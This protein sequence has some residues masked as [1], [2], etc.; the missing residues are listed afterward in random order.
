MTML[1]RRVFLS[2]ASSLVLLTACGQNA[3]ETAGAG[4]EVVLR[5]GNMAE[6]TSLNPHAMQGTWDHQI[7]GDMF[8]GL[9]TEDPEGRPVPAAAER[10]ETS[11]DGLTWTF[12]LRDHK[13]SDGQPVTAQHFIFAW[14]RILDPMLAAP[15]A[16]FLYPIKNARPINEGDMPADML[17]A[18][19]PDARTLVVQLEHPAPYLPEFMTHPTV[20]PLPQHVVERLG[21]DWIKPGNYVSNG[22]Y[23]LTNYVPNDNV[24]VVKNPQFYDAANVK[25]DKVIYFPTI[26][27]EAALRQFRAGELD[28][29]DRLPHAQIDWIRANIPE[30]LRLEPI[31]TVEY[32]AINQKRPPFNDVRV[33]EALSLA[34]DRDTITGTIRKLG[35]PPAYSMV[36]PGIANF[37]G[38][39]S[40]PF[41]DM[42]YAERVARAQQLMQQAGYGPQRRLSTTLRTRSLAAEQRRIPAAVQQMWQ[43]IYVDVEIVS[44]DP[45]QFY[46]LIQ[47]HDFDIAQ[48]GW[49]ADYNDASN[50]LELVT[51]GNQNNYGQYENPAYDRL[52]AQANVEV[53][54]Q[55]RAQMLTDAEAMALR[56]HVWVPSFFWVSNAL[57]KPYLK[58]WENNVADKHRV[59]WMSI[60]EAERARAAQQQ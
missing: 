7:I 18:T 34:L 13:W 17:G 1:S 10:W 60:D 47:E 43:S 48:A 46:D 45:A 42:P 57:V 11:E 15:Y 32:Y 35:E 30:T 5:W 4:G 49:Q 56:D 23:M 9:A 44:T 20:Y 52:L 37:T 2:T 24:T 58:G 25:I 53:D 16:Y 59:R 27:Y 50:F 38:G 6:P 31:L 21:E 41:K 3:P 12:H 26:D 54:L 28:Y 29:Q 36:P 33:R 51:T 22:P 14:R 40:L 8:M 55:K 19:A 39:N